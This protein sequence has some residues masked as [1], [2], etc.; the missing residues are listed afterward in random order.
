MI[1]LF[2]LIFM[3]FFLAALVFF[4]ILT[5]EK[6]KRKKT[7][8]EVLELSVSNLDNLFHYSV[9]SLFAPVGFFFIL[10]LFL[11]LVG[12]IFLLISPFLHLL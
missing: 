2:S 7:Y 1:L 11:V 9:L 3:Y 5:S 8:K 10:A 4:V 6:I 12:V